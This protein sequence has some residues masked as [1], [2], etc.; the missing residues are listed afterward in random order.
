MCSWWDQYH[1]PI[2]DLYLF[3]GRQAEIDGLLAQLNEGR[4]RLAIYG[5]R[6]CGKTTLLHA[7]IDRLP[8]SALGI[9]LDMDKAD[10]WASGSPLLQ[11]AGELG[12]K[13]REQTEAKIAPPESAVFGLDPQQAWQSFVDTLNAALAPRRVLLLLDNITAADAAWLQV[14]LQANTPIVC[15]AES[16]AALAERLPD[17]TRWPAFRLGPLDNEAAEDLVKALVGAKTAI[18]P[19]AVRRVIQAASHHPRYIHM[20]CRTVLDTHGAQGPITPLHVE[21]ALQALLAAPIGEFLVDWQSALPRE[22]I[23]MASFGALGHGGILTQYDVQKALDRCDLAPPLGDIVATLEGLVERHVLEKLGANSYRF[24]LELF[25]LWVARQGSLQELVRRNPWQFRGPLLG[26][27]GLVLRRMLAGRRNLLLSLG[28]VAA[29]IVLVAIQPVFWGRQDKSRSTG[30]AQATASLPVAAAVTSQTTHPLTPQPPAKLVGEELLLMSRADPEAAWQIWAVNPATGQRQRLTG[31]QAN[32][33]TPRWSPDGRRIAFVS[34]RDGDRDIYVI[35][36]N[37]TGGTAPDRNL[38]RSDVP[39]WQPAWSPDGTQIAYASYTEEN[40]D[41]WIVNVDGTG[42]VRVTEHAAD[43]LMPA[44]SPDGRQLLFVSRRTG[45]ADVFAHD[46]RTAE[47]TQLTTSARD[48]YDPAW[49]PSGKW[50]AYVTLTDGQED[51][52]VMDADGSNR[53]NITNSPAANESHPSWLSDSELI[54]ALYTAA[55][56]QHDIYTMPRDGSQIKPLVTGPTDD[57][58]PSPY[59]PR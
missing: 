11:I 53:T 52:F 38:T 31:F 9:Y 41:I 4:Q 25:R 19:W 30:T 28:V 58:A 7:L 44:W 46:L 29:V 15:A 43:D 35:D 23:V 49:S 2:R 26:H 17:A 1:P 37:A 12:R 16:E 20:I 55:Q 32:E 8:R 27:T 14:L 42:R 51:I 5:L 33:H 10:G 59:S 39:S 54:L 57:T 56:G 45:D 48:E 40:W 3:V 13:V 6:H 47:L 21:S 24:R 34:D 22:R 36:V 50:I 18:D